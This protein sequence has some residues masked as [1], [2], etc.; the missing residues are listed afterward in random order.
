MLYCDNRDAGR[1]AAAFTDNTAALLLFCWCC[2]FV[3]VCVQAH[4]CVRDA[5]VKAVN[6]IGNGWLLGRAAFASMK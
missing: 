5:D 1:T 3:C 6:Y 4:V 2:H